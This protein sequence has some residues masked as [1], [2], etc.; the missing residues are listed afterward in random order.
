MGGL[1]LLLVAI[2]WVL[3]CIAMSRVLTA[4][5]RH[6]PLR[7][8]VAIALFLGLLVAPIADDLLGTRAYQRYCAAADNQVKVFST[9]KVDR[10]TGLFS[11]TGE[12]RLAQLAPSEHDERHRLG[13]AADSL[14]RWD[15]GTP[16]PSS[17]FFPVN[18]RTTKIYDVNSGSL[19]A[20]FTSY[21]Y[22]GGFLRSSVLDERVSVF[23]SSSEVLSIKNAVLTLDKLYFEYAMPNQSINRTNNGVQRLCALASAVPP[24]FAPHLKG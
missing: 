6:G 7:L 10:N 4:A 19:V 5:I 2:G 14:V 8:L 20:Q 12:W 24:L 16:K 3:L 1:L 15:H 13:K 11:A 21:H 9:I 18:E 22:S 17:S 23:Q